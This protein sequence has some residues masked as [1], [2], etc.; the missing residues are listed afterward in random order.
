MEKGEEELSGTKKAVLFGDRLLDL[1]DEI[2]LPEEA[3]RSIYA[4]NF[5]RL[6]SAQPRP[7][8]PDLVAEELHR[9]AALCDALGASPNPARDVAA[10]LFQEPEPGGGSPDLYRHLV[11]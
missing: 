4:D 9:I 7:L 8:E 6:T 3:L 5:R 2:A 10:R 1:D 11:L